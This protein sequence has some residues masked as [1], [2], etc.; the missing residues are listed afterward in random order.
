MNKL[1]KDKRSKLT[2]VV[3]STVIVIAA[4]W[5]TLIE[6]QNAA[7]RKLEARNAEELQK[8]ESGVRTV[9]AKAS[10]EKRLG[11]AIKNLEEIEKSMA[12]GDLYDWII[13]TMKHFR[14]PYRDRVDI[15]NYSREVVGEMTMLPKFPYKAATY[16]I[17]GS[18]YFHDLGC[19]IADLETRF[20]F[21]RVQNLELEP[22]SSSSATATDDA[23]KL[24]FRFELVALIQP[25]QAQ[26]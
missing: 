1:T 18:A 2:L 12:K 5:F 22:A 4:I 6:G 26:P 23:E 16:S 25:E 15:P 10:I 9:D 14:A 8:L 3:V 24:A 19:F 13:K 21:M 20:P 17:R 7:I 11:V